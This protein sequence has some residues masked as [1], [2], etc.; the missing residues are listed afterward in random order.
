MHYMVTLKPGSSPEELEKAKEAAKSAGGK[1]T[2]ESTLIK[3]F[4]SVLHIP[5]P[6][7]SYHVLTSASV[8]VPDDKVSTLQT[9]EHVTVEADS[10]V[11]T[12]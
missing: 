8:D 5:A 1:I 7:C 4:K 11:H 12:Q 10:E 9:N 3:S 6:S 2:H